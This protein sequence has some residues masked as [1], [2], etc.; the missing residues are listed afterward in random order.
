MTDL[1]PTGRSATS[2]RRAAM[3]AVSLLLVP[4]LSACSFGDRTPGPVYVASP[5]VTA[6]TLKVA[7][8]PFRNLSSNSYA[9]DA[10]SDFLVTELLT[11]S[12]FTLVEPTEVGVALAEMGISGDAVGDAVSARDVARKLGVDAVLYGSVAEFAYS[13]SLREEPAVSMA[14]RLVS[15][16]TGK[17]LWAASGAEVGGGLLTQDSVSTTAIRLIGRMADDLGASQTRSTHR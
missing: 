17:V 3:L 7:V 1:L 16:E 15:A 6:G 2:L 11:R 9:G 12:Y 10:V 5:S 14:V 13:Y 4:L 8:L